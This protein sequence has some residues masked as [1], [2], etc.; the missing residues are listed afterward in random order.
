MTE[1]TKEEMIQQL[2]ARQDEFLRES[3]AART[4]GRFKDARAWEA[5]SRSIGRLIV[6][7]LGWS[8][9]TER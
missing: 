1:P 5:K 4:E 7:A 2:H 3:Q 8:R 9:D 6:K